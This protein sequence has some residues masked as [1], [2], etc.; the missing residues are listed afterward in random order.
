MESEGNQ[1]RQLGWQT[2]TQTDSRDGRQTQTDILDERH[3]HSQDRRHI[4]RIEDT[5]R[6]LGWKTQSV[7]TEDTD[8]HTVR[9]EDTDT[10]RMEDTDRQLGWKTQTQTESQDG[11]HRHSQDGRHRNRHTVGMKDTDRQSG[12]KTQTQ[13]DSQDRRHRHRETVR[14]EDTDKKSG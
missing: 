11:R 12:Q 7:R 5:D 2:R 6:Q 10:V 1:G 9:M 13:T 8:T 3:R 14:I 4:V